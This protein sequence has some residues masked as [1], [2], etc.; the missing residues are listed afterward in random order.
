LTIPFKALLGYIGMPTSEG[1]YSFQ[2][3]ISRMG[4]HANQCSERLWPARL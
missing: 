4:T 2:T 1:W 3:Y